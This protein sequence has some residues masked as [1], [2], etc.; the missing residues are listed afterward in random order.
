MSNPRP[1][2]FCGSTSVRKLRGRVNG[3]SPGPFIACDDCFANAPEH[4]W[5]SAPFEGEEQILGTMYISPI[6]RICEHG[7]EHPIVSVEWNTS[8]VDKLPVGT[9]HLKVKT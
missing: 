4:A 2:R 8:I 5:N 6:L 3:G 7:H 9:H 1:C